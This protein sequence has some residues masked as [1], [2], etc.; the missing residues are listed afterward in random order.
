[1]V[2]AHKSAKGPLP[3]HTR[4]H[5]PVAS[6][7]RSTT[8]ASLTTTTDQSSLTTTIGDHLALCLEQQSRELEELQFNL[9]SVTQEFVQY[10]ASQ[11]SMANNLHALHMTVKEVAQAMSA[12]TSQ[13]N[14]FIVPPVPASHTDP[15]TTLQESHARPSEASLGR[16]SK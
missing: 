6:P 13:L 2:A 14:S 16:P 15:Q 1:M 3:S 9:Q 8:M 7:G 10:Q 12:I 11:N 5:S 4:T